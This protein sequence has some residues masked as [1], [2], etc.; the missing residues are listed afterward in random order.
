M[1][2]E[3]YHWRR[4]AENIAWGYGSAS[5]VV[6]AWWGSTGHRRN[7]QDCRLR[8]IGVGVQISGG[9]IWWTQDFGRHR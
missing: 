4:V 3:G 9:R 6:R 7:I 8:H 1:T 5:G 2:R